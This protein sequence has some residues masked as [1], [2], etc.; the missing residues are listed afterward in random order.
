MRSYCVQV[1]LGEI[2]ESIGQLSL[3]GEVG[4]DLIKYLE[5]VQAFI[6]RC[7]DC[8]AAVDCHQAV[9]EAW[10]VAWKGIFNKAAHH[11]GDGEDSCGKDKD[12]S[13]YRSLKQTTHET[14][15]KVPQPVLEKIFEKQ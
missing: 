13:F 1:L 5:L 14:L 7:H 8:V 3:L 12:H 2:V 10:V 6:R 11:D 15:S 9:N 4:E